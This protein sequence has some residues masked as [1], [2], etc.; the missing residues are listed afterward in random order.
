MAVEVISLANGVLKNMFWTK[1]LYVAAILMVLGLA[2]GVGVVAWSPMGILGDEPKN[3]PVQKAPPRAQVAADPKPEDKGKTPE[4]PVVQVVEEPT[5]RED[6]TGRT[7]ALSSIQLRSRVTGYLVKVNAKDGAEV[8]KGDVLFEIDPRLY[9]AELDKVDAVLAQSAARLERARADYERAKTLHSKNAIS[10][11]E[12]AKIAGDYADAEAGVRVARASR[13]I[14]SLN[15]SFTKVTA[16]MS[17]ILGRRLFDVGSLV[18][19]D[20]T[21]L[22]TLA[23]RDPIVVIFD[24]D[25]RTVLRLRRAMGAAKAKDG[26]T[27]SV[28]MALADEKGFPRQGKI[29]TS[30][31]R[32]DSAGTVRLRAVFANTDNFLV[33]GLFCRV[34]LT[35]NAPN[36]AL[37]VPEG[38]WL[39]TTTC[40]LG[41]RARIT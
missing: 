28:A 23:S 36:K 29:E 38:H 37:F 27:L 25:E 18:K 11:E 40:G 24:I 15:L 16:P 35:L 20:E 22:A 13:E 2:G 30:D 8:K 39:V 26:V 32:V 7:E 41:S 21:V 10:Q 19:A 6:F 14:A 34:R 1:M 12:I 3:E 5:V 31:F 9:Q 4:V 17:G 33:P